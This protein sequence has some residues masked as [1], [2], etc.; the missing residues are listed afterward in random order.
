MFKYKCFESLLQ[1]AF[2]FIVFVLPGVPEKT[3]EVYLRFHK[4]FGV[5]IFVA[6]IAQCCIGIAQHSVVTIK[7]EKLSFILC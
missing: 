6:S 2:G 4:F 1:L 7:Y 3:K 5:S